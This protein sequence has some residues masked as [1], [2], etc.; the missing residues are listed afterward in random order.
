MQVGT[1]YHK[2]EHVLVD[3]TADAAHRL[4]IIKGQPKYKL[5]LHVKGRSQ[6]A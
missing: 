5:N 1:S 3:R 2:F 4:P 6:V